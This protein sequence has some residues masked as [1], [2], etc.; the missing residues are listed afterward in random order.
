MFEG[1]PKL[2]SLARRVREG[3]VV[4]TL[5]FRAELEPCVLRIVRRV[6]RSGSPNSPLAARIHSVAERVLSVSPS[7]SE[8]DREETIAQVASQICT[9]IV[10]QLRAIPDCSRA[11]CETV[12]NGW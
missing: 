7:K 4:G 5:Q 12:F 8:H 10:E 11:S 3:D 9:A 2:Q 1:Q 6:L